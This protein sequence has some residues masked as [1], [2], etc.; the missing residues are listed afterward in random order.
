MPKQIGSFREVITAVLHL[1]LF[2]IHQNNSNIFWIR[3][4][5]DKNLKPKISL[6]KIQIKIGYLFKYKWNFRDIGI[7]KYSFPIIKRACHLVSFP[8]I[9]G[10]SLLIT[11]DHHITNFLN[12]ISLVYSNILVTWGFTPQW[13]IAKWSTEDFLFISSK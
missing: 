1:I 4:V 11:N 8:L 12:L 10:K 3:E 9:D 7:K 5:V 6:L 13:C 2:L